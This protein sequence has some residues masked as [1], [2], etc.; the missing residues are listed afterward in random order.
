[1]MATVDGRTLD[2]RTLEQI[3]FQAVRRVIEDG[4]RPSEVMRSFGLCRTTIYPWLRE[5]EDQGWEA[6]AESIAEGPPPK[7]STKQKDQVKRWILGRNPRQYGFDSGLWSRR[8]AQQL[9]RDKMGIGLCLTSV[10][11]ILASLNLTPQKKLRQAYE[12]DPQAV[13]LWLEESY[14]KLKKRAKRLGAKIFFLDEARFQPDPPLGPLGRPHGLKGETPEVKTSGRRRSIYA[15]SAVNTRGE[16][17]AATYDGKLNAE[18]FVLFVKNFMEARRGR[19]F[20]VLDNHPCLKGTLVQ[21]YL[22]GLQG[23]LELHPLPAYAAHL[24][25]D[26]FVWRYTKNNGVSKKR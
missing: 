2:H 10:G 16:F 19:V 23:R 18:S 5:F 3:R 4:E 11:K 13:R 26:E 12:R 1:M 25:P 24:N 7:M 9:I 22:D 17:W 14:P 20:L 6:L 8:T 21:R 15:I